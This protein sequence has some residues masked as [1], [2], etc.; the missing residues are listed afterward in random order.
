M[1][2]SLPTAEVTL[3]HKNWQYL[4]EHLVSQFPIFL[5]CSLFSP[6]SHHHNYNHKP[7]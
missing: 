4:K 1:P 5:S 2:R 6:F 3:T 7:Q